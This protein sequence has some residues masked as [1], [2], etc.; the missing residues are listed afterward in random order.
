MTGEGRAPRSYALSA[1]LFVR[2]IGVVFVVAFLSLW[3]QLDALLGS[4][5]IA[6]AA[7]LMW[8]LRRDPDPRGFGDLPTLVWWGDSD[9]ELHALC[10]VGTVASLL[11]VVGFRPRSMLAVAWLLY[12]S[13]VVVGGPFLSFQWDALLLEAAVA[14][15]FVAPLASTPR[16]DPGREPPAVARWVIYALLFKLILSSGLVKLTSGDPTWRDLTALTFHYETQP[17]PHVVSW[18]AH[19]LPD[20]LHAVSAAAVLAIELGAPLLLPFPGWPRRVAAGLVAELMLLIS[21]TGNYGFF[22]LLTL[23]L[24]VPCVDD[25]VWRSALPARW[26]AHLDERASA[27]FEIPR[28]RWA[29]WP[30]AAL[31][32]ALVL[33][34]ALTSVVGFGGARW[35]PEPALAALRAA[36]PFHVVSPYGLFAHMTTDRPEIVIEG[37]DDGVTWLEY[38]LR[39]KAGDPTTRPPFVGLHM[40]RID[41]RLWF[42]ALGQEAWVRRLLEEMLYGSPAVMEQ[43]AHDPFGG[44]SPTFIRATLFD[45]R[46][47]DAATRDATGAWYRRAAVRRYLGPLRRAG[48]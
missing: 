32:S 42:A 5:G 18:Y 45:Y 25:A 9:P 26:L 24:C 37:S 38:E 33:A 11:L 13:L 47:T 17:L 36:R 41:W 27:P 6:P 19:Q 20:W 34:S 43:I 12:L 48:S 35:V 40:P 2:G 44:R 3:A 30:R 46:F 4:R 21:V 8:S 29:R 31:A 1:W 15:L 7:G 14:A 28:A 23:V 10:A 39:Y 16:P 22:N